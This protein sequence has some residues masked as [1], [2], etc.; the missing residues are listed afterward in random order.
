VANLL[1]HEKEGTEC[2]QEWNPD[3]LEKLG[4]ADC[5]PG[6][7]RMAEQTAQLHR[8][9]PRGASERRRRHLIPSV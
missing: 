9:S 2:A 5:L 3:F 1:A 6:W 4:V 7:K 8:D